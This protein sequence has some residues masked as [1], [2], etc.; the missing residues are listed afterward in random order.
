MRFHRENMCIA[1]LRRS[2]GRAESVLLT[3][4]SLVQ[5]TSF[6]C[7]ALIL[8][9]LPFL[10]ACCADPLLQRLQQQEM[11][12]LESDREISG[13]TT[14]QTGDDIHLIVCGVSLYVGSLC[15]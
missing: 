2:C 12:A 4:T 11:V 3:L 6:G 14:R 15:F 8:D 1:T 10:R 7:D 5:S 9:P 13:D